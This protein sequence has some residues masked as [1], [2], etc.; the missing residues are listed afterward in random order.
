[1]TVLANIHKHALTIMTTMTLQKKTD[2]TDFQS[3]FKTKNEQT[4]QA[5]AMDMALNF[6]TPNVT[7]SRRTDFGS[8]L[9]Q[10]RKDLD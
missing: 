9:L 2:I 10:L 4:I 5:N 1:M 8:D 6:S 7:K 3:K